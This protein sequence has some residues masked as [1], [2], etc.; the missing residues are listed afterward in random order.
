MVLSC[1]PNMVDKKGKIA[2]YFPNKSY[3]NESW[4]STLDM[5]LAEPKQLPIFSVISKNTLDKWCKK[6]EF[7]Y[8]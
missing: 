5:I 8:M 1:F 6:L 2:N 7:S 4:V 3:E